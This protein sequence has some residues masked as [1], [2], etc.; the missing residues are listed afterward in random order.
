MRRCCPVCAWIEG[1]AGEGAKFGGLRL[2]EKVPRSEET[3]YFVLSS[4][5]DMEMYY[6]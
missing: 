1:V 4:L 6:F 3:A 2:E 5:I